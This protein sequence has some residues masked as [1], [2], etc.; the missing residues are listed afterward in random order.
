MVEE[1]HGGRRITDLTTP[2]GVTYRLKKYTEVNYHS[3]YRLWIIYNGK[4]YGTNAIYSNGDA[5]IHATPERLNQDA[6]DAA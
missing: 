1:F 6:R 2:E 4:T 3:Y 5:R